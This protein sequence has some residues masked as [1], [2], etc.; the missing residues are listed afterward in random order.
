MIPGA[1]AFEQIRADNQTPRR[2]CVFLTYSPQRSEWLIVRR[3]INLPKTHSVIYV[4]LRS[5]VRTTTKSTHGSLWPRS[6]SQ[7]KWF[8]G[9]FASMYQ[10]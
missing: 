10:L 7:Y 6:F 4:S 9:Y 2:H 5:T 8:F 3:Q 1:I